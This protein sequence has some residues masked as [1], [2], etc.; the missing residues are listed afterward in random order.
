MSVPIFTGFYPVYQGIIGV[1]PDFTIPIAAEW[2]G[3]TS[4]DIASLPPDLTY[5]ST[6]YTIS[7]PV[8]TLMKYTVYIRGVNSFGA[9]DWEP[10]YIEVFNPPPTPGG[11][12][13]SLRTLFGLPIEWQQVVEI[14]TKSVIFIKQATLYAP[15]NFSGTG[16]MLINDVANDGNATIYPSNK[17]Y[18]QILTNG[19]SYVYARA[20]EPGWEIIVD[21]SVPA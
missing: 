13:S 9:A 7:G 15:G 8:T 14:G 1:P 5:D 11:M 6:S 16:R 12:P 20:T 21:T 4:F 3:A 2:T 10:L 17:L 18:T 19:G